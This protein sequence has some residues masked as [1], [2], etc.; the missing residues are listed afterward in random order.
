MSYD[1]QVINQRYTSNQGSLVLSPGLKECA[2]N[3]Y[4]NPGSPV[5]SVLYT[6][7]VFDGANTYW[8]AKFN[9]EYSQ[10][11]EGCKFIGG[12]VGIIDICRGGNIQFKKC[13]FES[14]SRT[15]QVRIRGGAKNI[16]FEDCNFK[17]SSISVINPVFTFGGWSL[18]DFFDR[19][20]CRNIKIENCKFVKSFFKGLTIY[21]EKINIKNSGIGWFGLPMWLVNFYW[22]IKRRALKDQAVPSSMANVYQEEL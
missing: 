19:P 11:F 6:N 20:F 22:K 2:M 3:F 14:G 17:R 21:S 4:R 10:V 15:N 9:L 5:L 8:S 13:N 12:S 1:R 7:C 16:T 18:F